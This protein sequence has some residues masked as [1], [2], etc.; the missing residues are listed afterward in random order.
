MIKTIHLTN[1]NSI[2]QLEQILMDYKLQRL[3][4]VPVEVN[5]L[6]LLMSG[7]VYWLI[8][9]PYLILLK[10]WFKM[11]GNYLEMRGEKGNFKG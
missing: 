1:H 6:R 7:H 8:D 10:S 3:A 9:S 4:I 2:C 5:P 11:Q